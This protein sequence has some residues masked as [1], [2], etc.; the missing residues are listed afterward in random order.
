MHW[1]LFI[2]YF[3]FIKPKQKV[4]RTTKIILLN[5]SLKEIYY[6]SVADPPDITWVE[7]RPEIYLK[8]KPYLIE[9]FLSRKNFCSSGGKLH[10]AL[11]LLNFDV[12]NMNLSVFMFWKKLS[13][14]PCEKSKNPEARLLKQRM[15][16]PKK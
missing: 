1:T 3:I 8:L 2:W 6:I 9:T 12:F 16:S 4:T 5:Y 14:L 11:V 15:I 13:T 7:Y 10:L